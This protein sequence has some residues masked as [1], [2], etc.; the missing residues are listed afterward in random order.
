MKVNNFLYRVTSGG[1]K[2]AAAKSKSGITRVKK[3]SI[4]AVEPAEKYKTVFWYG[5]EMKPSNIRHYMRTTDPET[6][7]SDESDSELTYEQVVDFIYT[8]SKNNGWYVLEYP[9]RAKDEPI[10]IIASHVVI[11]SEDDTDTVHGFD[12]NPS[13]NDYMKLSYL[14]NNIPV[15]GVH[16]LAANK[17]EAYYKVIER[18]QNL[19]EY[20]R[21]DQPKIIRPESKCVVTT[22]TVCYLS[23]TK[24]AS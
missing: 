7:G 8:L 5:I 24:K 16:N 19:E 17:R 14:A 11:L 1:M 15:R 6:Y 9:Q 13:I 2:K 4:K 3:S 18:I 21:Y 10:I 20:P 23:P 22:S 12:Y